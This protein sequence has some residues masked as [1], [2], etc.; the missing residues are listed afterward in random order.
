MNQEAKDRLYVKLGALI[1]QR[2]NAKGL[3]QIEVA[4]ELEVDRTYYSKIENGTKPV[5]IIRLIEICNILECSSSELIQQLEN[6]E[7]KNEN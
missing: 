1:A 3:P 5:S 4:V 2:R 6:Q 7:A